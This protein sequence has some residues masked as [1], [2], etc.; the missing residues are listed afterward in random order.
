[1]CADNDLGADQGENE[2]RAGQVQVPDRVL[3]SKANGVTEKGIWMPITL[4]SSRCSCYWFLTDTSA[5]PFHP[6]SCPAKK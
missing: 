2:L 1:M 4:T 3:R 6:Q 5:L